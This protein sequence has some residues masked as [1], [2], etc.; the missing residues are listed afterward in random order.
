[1]NLI[2]YITM[3]RMQQPNH[4]NIPM[5]YRPNDSAFVYTEFGLERVTILMGISM[6]ESGAITYAVRLHNGQVIEVT[7]DQLTG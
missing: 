3:M 2:H 7:E 5:I 6:H 4:L 1:M